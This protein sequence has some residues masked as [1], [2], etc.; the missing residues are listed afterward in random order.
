MKPLPPPSPRRCRACRGS[1]RRTD[2]EPCATF[3]CTEPAL[4][5]RHSARFN[6]VAC[7]GA[8]PVPSC[9][10]RGAAAAWSAWQTTDDDVPEASSE[11]RIRLAAREPGVD[12]D[13]ETRSVP[14]A[15]HVTRVRAY[16]HLEPGRATAAR[17]LPIAERAADHPALAWGADESIRRGARV[18]EGDPLRG[19]ASHRR[20][21][22]LHRCAVGR[23]RARHR[24]LPR[25]G[26]RLERHRLQLA[27]RQVRAGVR[28]PL[29]R[30]R[31]E[32]DRRALARLQHRLGRLAVLGDVPEDAADSG[33]KGALEQLLAWRLDIAHIDP[34]SIISVDSGGNPT[35]PAGTP[36]NLRA[37]SG[38]RDTNFTDC[39]GNALYAQCR[40]SRFRRGT[41]A[42]VRGRS[43]HP[44]CATRR[45][46]TRTRRFRAS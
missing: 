1:C 36:V 14:H 7:T 40:R 45:C 30:G 3:R 25:E 17:R 4:A 34:L 12:R 6:M 2:D 22:Q 20:D 24:A 44:Y 19:R 41:Q 27:R 38:H 21:E 26:E 8:A 23:D 10:A 16:L 43:A 46:W 42:M 39:P 31:Q 18:R 11:N 33:R 37:I 28:G 5:R 13:S 32:G 29:R 9:S 15:G 35:F